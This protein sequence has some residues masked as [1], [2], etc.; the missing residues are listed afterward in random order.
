MIFNT[1]KIGLLKCVDT[2]KCKFRG[3]RTC[4]ILEG[5]PYPDGKCPFY[6]PKDEPE[7]EKK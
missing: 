5:D 4:K 6:K 1:K 3:D 7:E 2:R